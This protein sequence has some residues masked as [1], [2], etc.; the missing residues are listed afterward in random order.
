VFNCLNY[1]EL[2][3]LFSVLIPVF[4]IYFDFYF[5]YAQKGAVV[6]FCI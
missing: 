5:V 3:L 6:Y 4:I 2:L 1:F